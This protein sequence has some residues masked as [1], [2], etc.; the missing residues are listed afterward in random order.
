M[1]YVSNKDKEKYR[2][3]CK[4]KKTIPLFIHD[5]YMDATCENGEVWDVILVERNGV[6]VG[7]FPYRYINRRGM[8][9]IEKGG[10]AGYRGGIWFEFENRV[11]NARRETFIADVIR[12]IVSSLPSYDCFKIPFD[13]G[14]DDWHQ[15][16]CLGFQQTTRYSYVINSEHECIAE[17]QLFSGLQK[18]R[19]YILR[20][21]MK[22][23]SVNEEINIDEYWTLFE[24]GNAER[25]RNALYSKEAFFRITNAALRHNACKMVKAINKQGQVVASQIVMMDDSTVYKIFTTFVGQEGSDANVLLDW[26]CITSAV[27]EGKAYDFAGGMDINIAHYNASFNA[28]KMPYFEIEKHSKKYKLYALLRDIKNRRLFQDSI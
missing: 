5:W 24:K 11:S 28:K 13:L 10:I 6:V 16:Y 9:Y 12:E 21:A 7:A 2:K 17:E 8:Y 3:L 27:S 1:E 23:F 4:E 14:F 26:Y 25:N 19:R 22:N 15:F 18:K 20:Q